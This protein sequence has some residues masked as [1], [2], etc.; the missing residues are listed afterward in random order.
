MTQTIFHSICYLCKHFD[1]KAYDEKP[2]EFHCEAFPQAI[3]QEIIS[4]KFD[5]RMPYPNDTGIRFEKFDNGEG[6]PSLLREL[7]GREIAI[8]P[9]DYLAVMI[10]H[11]EQLRLVGYALPPLTQN[12]PNESSDE[13][14]VTMYIRLYSEAREKH[15]KG[16]EQFQ[17][18]EE[19][20]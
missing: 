15:Q 13:D 5:H 20:Q 7:F 8:A 19:I 14:A 11:I 17:D 3:P 10:R 6:L 12:N 16:I 4:R 2:S 18:S 9:D 1:V